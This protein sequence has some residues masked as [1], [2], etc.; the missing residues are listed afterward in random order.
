MGLFSNQ[1]SNVVEWNESRDDVI[2]WLWRNKEIKRGSRL[3]IRPGQDAIF[4]Y[5]GKIEGIFKDEGNYE[6]ESE[7][8]PFLT[9]LKGFKFGFNTPLRAEVLFVNTKEFLIRWG[10]K[11]A[12]NIPTTSLKGGLPIRSFGTFS[13]KIHDYLS[14]IDRVA[15][16][17]QQFTVDDVKERVLAQLDQLLMRWISKEGKDMFNLQANSYEIA[18]GIKMDLDMELLKLG[19]TVTDFTISSFTYP[20][21]VQKMIEKT[22][23]YD[24]V[25][26][27]A[28]YQQMS[29]IDSLTENPNSAMASMAQ[30]GAGLAMGVEMMKHMSSIVATPSTSPTQPQPTSVT[31]TCAH[32]GH[33]LNPNAKFCPECGNKVQQQPISSTNKSPKFCPD[34]GHKT[35][36]G[37]KFCHEC[38]HKLV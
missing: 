30:T 35:T 25:G 34:C 11:N 2:F 7:I 21:N 17:K 26:D 38:G 23:S 14:L 6:I 10:T 3:I 18:N 37:T 31:T 22:A 32:C 15:G 36:P 13:V 29:M 19:L 20:E 24:M 16:V 9:T 1:F 8:I 5:N 28:H 33:H 27:V 12:I 4:L